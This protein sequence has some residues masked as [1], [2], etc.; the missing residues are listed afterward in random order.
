[1]ID[2]NGNFLEDE[3]IEQIQGRFR[4]HIAELTDDDLEIE[5]EKLLYHVEREEERI[6][7]SID[8]I[9]IYA[10][11]ILTVIPIESKR[12]SASFPVISL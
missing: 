6:N 10:T 4:T 9:N 1:M 7:T 11:I 8:K 3:K 12:F 2:I 5:K